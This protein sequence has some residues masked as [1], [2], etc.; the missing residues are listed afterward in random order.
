MQ[1]ISG[2]ALRHTVNPAMGRL[3]VGAPRDRQGVSTC[4]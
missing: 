4:V 1:R 2:V 3:E